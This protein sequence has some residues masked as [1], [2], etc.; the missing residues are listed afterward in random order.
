MEILGMVLFVLVGGAAFNALLVTVSLLLPVPVEAARQKLEGNLRRVFLV[1]M[2]N[3]VFLFGL[4][5]LLVYIFTLFAKPVPSGMTI[6]LGQIIGPGIFMTLAVLLALTVLAFTLRGLSA[7]ASLLGSRIGPARSQFWS[8]ARGGM[9]LVLAC[10]TPYVGWFVFTPFVLSLALGAS[11]M[12]LMKKKQ[13]P[14]E[15]PA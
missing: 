11:V 10:L 4:L 3:L 8:E 1:G 14:R 2:I 15:K 13:A 9:L 7:L 6:D 12:T 5:V